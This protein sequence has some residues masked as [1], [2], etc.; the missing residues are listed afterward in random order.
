MIQ[1]SIKGTT[2][3]ELTEEL[4][5]ILD[6]WAN[7]TIDLSNG[8]F[9]A[10]LNGEGKPTN[11]DEKGA[12]LNARI[13][14]CFSAAYNFVKDPAYLALADRAYDYLIK[15][16]WDKENGGLFWSVSNKGSVK[17]NRKQAYAQGFGMYGFSEYFKASGKQECLEYAIKLF[18]LIEANYKDK[19][20]GGYI[21]ALGCNWQRL[22]DMRLSDKDANEPK[23]MN[24]H[25]HIIEPY[26]N[27]YRVWPNKLLKN[28]IQDLL[29]TFRDKII[30]KQTFH[31]N[32][33]F[34]MDWTVK[35]SIVS[36][37]HDIEGAW[38][39]NEAAYII[40]DNEL[41]AQM[42]DL[43]LK[44]V[45]ASIS[46]GTDKDGSIFY[47]LEDG[48]LDTDKHWWPQAEALVGLLDAYQKSSD[49]KYLEAAQKVWDFILKYIKDNENGEWFWKVDSN[50]K[51][52]S[53]T[54]KVGF[55]KCPYHNSRA[56]IEAITRIKSL[57]F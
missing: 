33:F 5:S 53:E 30:D 28:S 4:N 17:N 40:Q 35:S 31:F 52:D 7:K 29:K 51:P 11:A 8:G 24:T 36:Y 16:F 21:E 22:D 18:D 13:L 42:K 49:T 32:L 46:E 19:E 2:V 47:E 26:T 57:C 56:L 20:F 15:H 34:D 44:M 39:L 23:S 54:P 45:N 43:S 50:G 25:L 6:F 10:E 27:L 41:M 1:N 14:W 12:V 55:W 38:L 37:G 48:H 9:V 3:P